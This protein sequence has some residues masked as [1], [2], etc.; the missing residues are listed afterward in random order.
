LRE[1]YGAEQQTIPFSVLSTTIKNLMNK[2][3]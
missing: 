1:S 2:G 3:E